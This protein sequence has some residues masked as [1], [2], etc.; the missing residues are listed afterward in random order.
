M[1]KITERL[2]E[3]WHDEQDH[4]P[5]HGLSVKAVVKIFSVALILVH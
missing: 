4:S 5:G 3:L 1:I 2:P